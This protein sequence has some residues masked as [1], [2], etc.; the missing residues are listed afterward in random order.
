MQSKCNQKA[1]WVC[2]D[3]NE[4][5]TTVT[6]AVKYWNLAIVHA[7]IDECT[8]GIDGVGGAGRCGSGTQCVNT[9]GSYE[10]QCLAGYVR[11]DNL[12]CSEH[13][14]C[15][16]GL[17]GCHDNASCHNT[18][19]GYQCH[20]NDGYHGDGVVCTRNSAPIFFCINLN[21]II[22]APFMFIYS[23]WKVSLLIWQRCLHS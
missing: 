21:S 1:T 12:T 7:D 14:E 8:E 13:D 23:V 5:R 20:C 4:S 22:Y 10:C 17:H 6:V 16:T 11:R 18:P 2:E 3:G 15:A 19:G 9:L